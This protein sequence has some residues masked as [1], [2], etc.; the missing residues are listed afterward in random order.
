[1][2]KEFI[3]NNKRTFFV[4]L[5]FLAMFGIFSVVLLCRKEEFRAIPEQTA[6][7]SNNYIKG[8]ENIIENQNSAEFYAPS[9]QESENLI[10]EGSYPQPGLSRENQNQI[11]VSLTAGEKKY[12]AKI[13][14]GSSVFQLMEK[15]TQETDFR[16]KA[17]E[18]S[19]LGF[20]IEE[21]NGTVNDARANKFWLFSVNGISSNTGVSQTKLKEGDE[22]KWEFK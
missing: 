22:I 8:P 15:L 12:L 14:A 9:P 17:Q 20:F 3:Q 16:F 6:R 21:I 11:S 19:G 2:L 1:M 7:M 13:D 10:S 4:F 5:F 18:F